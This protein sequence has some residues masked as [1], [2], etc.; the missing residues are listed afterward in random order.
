MK[1]ALR[2]VLATLVLAVLTGG[3]ISV[4]FSQR[5]EF[6][7]NGNAVANPDFEQWQNGMATGWSLDEKVTNKGTVSQARSPVHGGQFSLRLSPNRNN[8]A[9]DLGGDPFGLGQAFSLAPLRGKRVYVSA[10]LGAN[11]GATALAGVYAVTKRGQVIAGELKEPSGG[12]GL[13]YQENFVDLPDSSEIS[14]VVFLVMVH[15]TSGSAFIDDFYVGTRPRS[16]TSAPG[17][18]PGRAPATPPGRANPRASNNPGNL[19]KNTGFDESANGLP[20]SWSLDQRVANKGSVAQV[21]TPS[22]TGM[23]LKLSPNRNNTATD[24][25]GGPFGVAQS[26]PADQFRG[27]TVHISGYLGAEN[28]ATAVL[29]LYALTSSGQVFSA[30]L[31]EPSGGSGLSYQQAEL[32]VPNDRSVSF[33]IFTCLAYG[34]SGNVYFDD[35]YVGFDAPAAAASNNPAPRASGGERASGGGNR[36]SSDAS[37]S[38]RADRVI[39][40]IP[41]GLYGTNIEWIWDANGIWDSKASRLNGDVVRLV[42]DLGPSL[43]RFP[44]GFFSD[45]YN[46]RDGTGAQSSR[47]ET[48]SM[49][50]GARSRHVFGTDE[51]LTFADA[52][53]GQ[54]LITVNAGTGTPQEAAEWVKYVNK[55][56][57]RVEYWEIGN[58]LYV[59]DGSAHSKAFTMTPDRYARKVLDFAKAM[60]AADPSIKIGA[61]AE[62]SLNPSQPKGYRNW[63]EEVLRTAGKEIDFIA[64][65]NAYAPGLHTDKGQ[66]VRTVYAAMLAAPLYVRQSIERLSAKIDSL[67]PGSRV[68]IAITEFGPYFQLTPDGRFT[69]HVKTLG[70]ALYVASVMKVFVENPRTDI[71][72]SFKLVDPLFTGWIGKKGDRFLP[73]GPYYAS[74]M[75]TRHFGSKLVSSSSES[76]TYTSESVGIVDR[77]YQVPYLD[78]IASKSDDGRKLYVLVVN[79][80][81]DKPIKARI[82]V[83]GFRPAGGAAW[84][85]NGKGVD[86]NT[87]TAPPN[88]GGVKWAR[89]AVDEVGRQFDR[90]APEELGIRRVAIAGVGPNFEYEFPAH[91]IVS[92]ELDGR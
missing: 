50:G 62:E 8:T 89:Q 80:H 22:Q 6:A 10:W 46:W 38:V 2:L 90:G 77:M 70:S 42:R 57:R 27:K 4:V 59:N 81:F 26:F 82:D 29:G 87:G 47:K 86:S 12:S 48:L 35:V 61:I 76:P 71:A 34:T 45:F 14:F 23:G 69:D 18:A 39:R 64:V 36:E 55:G 73:T 41:T 13:T 85:L 88:I 60:R 63:T 40:D 58:E 84:V 21:Q 49:P 25:G 44:G 43:I 20:A 24:L 54:L 78:V 31:K 51:A 68:K 92:L 65:H 32:V 1:I 7:A 9:T 17:G 19:A 16:A 52:V 3:L 33:L 79:K 28:G 56:R 72:N 91:S 83:Q 53:N 5:A 11:G 30:E 37:I 75:Y 67:A 15:G 66:N 74:Q